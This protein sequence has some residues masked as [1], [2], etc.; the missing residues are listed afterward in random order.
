MI[1]LTRALRSA[2]TAL[3]LP[4]LAALVLAA[5]ACTPSSGSLGSLATPPSA[6]VPSVEAPSNDQTP[7]PT[8]SAT[9]PSPTATPPDS[10]ATAGS[11][12]SPVLS[13]TPSAAGTTIVRAYFFLGSFT[14]SGGLVPVLRVVP[15]TVAVATAAMKALIAGPNDKELGATPAMYTTVPADTRLLG[16]SI[17]GGVATVNLSAEFASGGSRA[18]TFGRLAQVV[19]TLTQFPTVDHVLFELDGQS[20]F[21]YFGYDAYLDHPV[22]RSDFRDQLPGIFVDR[23]AWGAVLGNPGIVSG[24]AN[25]FEAQFLV[26]LSDANGRVLVEQPV[27]ADCGNGCWGTFST[28]LPYTVAQGQWG[29]LRVYDPAPK[30]G[31][32]EHVT[33]YPVWLAPAG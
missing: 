32:P 7:Q 31:T 1:R 15:K 21:A 30:D 14:G 13:P 20:R 3:V 2:R 17:S 10:S 26:R 18:S 4:C 5:A 33:D 19:Y 28:S 11:T 29:T 25:V 24:V 16:I 8:P 6:S 27:M 23:P 22:Y 9:E 12:A